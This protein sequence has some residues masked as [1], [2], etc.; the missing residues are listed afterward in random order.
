VLPRYRRQAIG[1]KLMDEAERLI[2]E[3][4]PIIGIGVGLDSDCGAAQ[5][6]YVKRGYPRGARH[7]LS[8]SPHDLG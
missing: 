4:S 6:L 7:H 5:R 2:L 8:R 3:R 1:T